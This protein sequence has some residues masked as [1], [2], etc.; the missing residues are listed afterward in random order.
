MMSKHQAWLEAQQRWR[1]RGSYGSTAQVC[2]RTKK[3][4][5]RCVVGYQEWTDSARTKCRP[6]LIG[7]G[8]TWEEAFAC[9]DKREAEGLPPLRKGF[10]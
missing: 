4:A 2:L 9:A 7:E 10:L 1:L 5:N 6:L 8:R 3:H